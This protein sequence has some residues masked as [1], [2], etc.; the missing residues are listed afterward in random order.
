VLEVVRRLLAGTLTWMQVYLD[1]ESGTM[2]T[3]DATP[4]TVARM[5]GV[6][7]RQL[8]LKG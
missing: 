7:I 2:R 3:V 6:K 5:T 8:V 1:L 4:E